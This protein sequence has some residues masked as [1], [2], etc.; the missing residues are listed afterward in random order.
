[1]RNPKSLTDRSIL[2]SPFRRTISEAHSIAPR[3][4]LQFTT[5]VALFIRQGKRR[6]S[7]GYFALEI[8]AS[9][10]SN[11]DKLLAAFLAKVGDRR[12]MR[13]RLQVRSPQF[14]SGFC[15]KRAEAAICCRADKNQPAGRYNRAAEVRR[16]GFLL[17]FHAAKRHLPGDF[18][19][20]HVHGIQCSPRRL[21]TRPFVLIP[22]PGIFPVFGTP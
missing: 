7:I 21:L 9:S 16:A 2:S 10:G 19:L 18:S 14:L 11:H 15:I 6:Q 12:R 8:S 4:S 13:A 1:M 22:K 20:V 17:Q 5:E 3:S